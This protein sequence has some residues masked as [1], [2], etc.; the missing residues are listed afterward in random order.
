MSVSY[1]CALWIKE[2]STYLIDK[3]IKIVDPDLKV[4]KF[5]VCVY[6]VFE[7]KWNGMEVK[8]LCM[9]KEINESIVKDKST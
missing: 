2:H 9:R 4:L 6:N 1:A 7:V 8:R 3:I 5:C